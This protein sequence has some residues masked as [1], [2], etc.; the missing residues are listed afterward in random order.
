MKEK[1]QQFGKA[2]LVPVSLIALS[3]LCLG[4]GGALTTE[5]TMTSLGVNWEWYSTS[6]IFNFFSV[7]KGLGNV[8]IG[9]LGVLYAVGCAFSLSRKEKG[10]AAFSALICFLAMQ[11]TM[12][13]LLNAAGY[14]AGNV[15]VDYLVSTGMTAIEASK[16]AGLYTTSLGFFCYNTGV[17][18]GI[19]T[20]VLVAWITTKF[21]NTKLP[22]ALS[23]FAG[24]RTIPIISMVSG[25]ILGILFFYIWPTIG[26]LFTNLA[27]FV[28]DSGLVGTFVYRLVDES[29]V[30]FGMHPILSTPMRWTELGGV[31]MVDGVRVVG[32]SAIQLAQLASPEPGKL[33]VRAFMGGAGIINFALYPGEALAMYH[34]ARK[35]NKKKVAGL[36]IPTIIST[37]CFGVTEPILFTFLF[38]APWLYF[39]VHA[40]LAALGEVACEFFEISIFQGNI[41]DWIPCFLRPEKINMVPYLWLMPIFFIVAYVLFRFLITKFNVPTPGREED[42]DT[43]DIHLISKDEYNRKM[44]EAKGETAEAKGETA[45]AKAE[46]GE[47]EDIM[48]AKDII[49]ALGGR[50]NILDVDNCISR[51]RIVVKDS[52]IVAKDEVFK[53]QLKA[54]GVVHM[55]EKALQ[56]IYGPAVGGIAADVRDVLGI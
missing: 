28:S 20:G 50:D 3:G 33:L 49:L 45:K 22:V 10:W 41:K 36:L 44:A 15:T 29:L 4:L 38:T 55:G 26:G 6:F 8:I 32:N 13:V 5:L 25:G 42:V 54:M 11:N 37:T 9:N 56:I 35:E 2:M 17:F 40:P 1:F 48:L 52:S 18:G 27:A 23:F 53:K 14:N 31:A 16:I 21:Y 39:L 46:T 51:L 43:E 47:S 34:C 7:I 12:Q 24:T 19:A 30:P